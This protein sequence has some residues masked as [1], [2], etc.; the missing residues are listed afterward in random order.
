MSLRCHRALLCFEGSHYV[1]ENSLLLKQR[2]CSGFAGIP[3]DL[4]VDEL[5]A[6][7][8]HSACR[9]LA[10]LL[11]CGLILA[12]SAEAAAA[13]Q[14]PA[15]FRRARQQPSPERKVSLSGTVT[16]PINFNQ[17]IRP[18]EGASPKRKAKFSAQLPPSTH[19]SSHFMLSDQVS[20]GY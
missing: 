20:Y 9:L 3:E 10:M 4:L 17:D 13:P 15:I 1:V 5:E 6:L 16:P 18:V 7:S 11:G 2:F 14:P 8:P 19:S 12:R